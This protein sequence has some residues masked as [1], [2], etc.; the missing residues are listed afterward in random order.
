M[1]NAGNNQSCVLQ[2]SVSSV[3]TWE[4]KTITFPKPPVA[5]TW[6]YSFGIGLRIRFA[7]AA[8]TS[9]QGGAGNWT[10]TNVLATSAQ[11]NF[12]GT[13]NSTFMISGVQLEEGSFS[14]PLE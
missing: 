2:Y 6:D 11:V 7:L 14:H 9:F 13:V 4:H 8:G 1:V 12:M 10:A 5:G 3:A